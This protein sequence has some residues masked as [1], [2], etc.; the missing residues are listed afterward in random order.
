MCTMT[1]VIH[2]ELAEDLSSET[3]INT[4]RRVSARQSWP[5]LMI[6]SNVTIFKADAEILY[7]LDENADVQNYLEIHKIA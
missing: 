5:N 4:L 3:F 2:V 7:L 6:S 1:C